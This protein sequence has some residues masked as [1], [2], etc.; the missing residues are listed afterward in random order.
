MDFFGFGGYKREPEGFASWQHLLFVGSLIALMVAL[1]IVLGI[2]NRKK[3]EKEKN[4]PLIVAAISIDAIEIFKIIILCI[5]GWNFLHL[6]PLFLCSLQLI[7][8]PVAAFGRGRIK[9][10]GLDYVFIFGLLGAI[11]GTVG[12]AQN[13]NAY[14]V[15][16]IENVSSG[17]THCISGFGCLYIGVSGMKSLKKENI[18]IELVIFVVFCV[19]AY[20]AN[21]LIPYNYMFLMRDDGTPYS[22][23]TNMVGGNK[24]LYPILV[25]GTLLIYIFAF[26]GVNMLLGKRKK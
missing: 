25:V 2:K 19:I 14:P 12:A 3:G 13:Y 6:L 20:V 1:A 23:F 11:L 10:I 8:L 22:I 17:L 26:F 24:V 4:L 9:E 15:L 21:L 18:V 7:T 5:K 16:G